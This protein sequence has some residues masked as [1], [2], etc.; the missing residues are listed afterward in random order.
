MS[1]AAEGSEIVRLLT[2]TDPLRAEFLRNLLDDAG[3]P[4]ELGGASQAGLTGVLPIEILV[5]AA[6]AE[7][8]RQLIEEVEQP[9]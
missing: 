9:E 8:A 3:I 2:V 5:R 1:H 7:Q 6:D 4:C